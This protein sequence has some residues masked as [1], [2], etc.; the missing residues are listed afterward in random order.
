ME[1]TIELT[2]VILT[3]VAHCKDANQQMRLPAIHTYESLLIFANRLCLKRFE[4][5]NVMFCA[6]QTAIQ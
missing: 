1:V 5:E 6:V 3:N 4:T 2:L